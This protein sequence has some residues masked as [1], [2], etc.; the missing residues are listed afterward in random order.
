[1]NE[2]YCRKGLQKDV[3]DRRCDA[4]KSICSALLEMKRHPRYIILENV[5]GFETSEAHKM[6][7][8][9]LL[10]ANYHIEVSKTIFVLMLL[11][12][13]KIRLFFEMYSSDGIMH[14]IVIRP[15][16]WSI[17]SQA[18]VWT[19]LNGVILLEYFF[20]QL[21]NTVL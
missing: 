13:G 17:I 8:K 10:T 4:L 7:I 14:Q 21:G 15:S 1:M 18:N 5:C 16:F 6:L 9:S 19:K 2:W 12:M 11:C 20:V 3:E